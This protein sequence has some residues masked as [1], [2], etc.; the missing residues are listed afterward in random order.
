MPNPLRVL[1][2]ASALGG[3]APSA[4]ADVVYAT[5]GPFGG[6]FGVIGFDVFS[7]QSVGVRFVPTQN[8]RLD[9]I[10]VWLMDNSG[11]SHPLVT[12]EVRADQTS[13]GIS[14]P[15]SIV[16]ESWTF[17]IAAVGWVPQQE[18]V[19]SSARPILEAGVRTWIVAR[20]RSSAGMNPVWNW[21]SAGAGFVATTN[22]SP[23][24]WQPGGFGAVVSVV[25]EGTPWS[26]PSPD[27]NGDGIVGG[28]DLTI[29]LA[30]WGAC[31]PTGDCVADLVE[32]GQ[33]DGADLAALLAAWS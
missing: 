23:E 28:A 7:Q 8:Y 10:K 25:V 30:A 18:T 22:G 14:I 20:S 32:N 6:P 9:R 27:L 16:R 24:A 15:S 13:G 33:V 29:L 3:L 19:Q 1:L 12:L 4:G 5:S 2:V 21:A 26:P 31:S 17:P 11:G